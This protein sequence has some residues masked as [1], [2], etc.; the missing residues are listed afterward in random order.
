MDTNDKTT[1]AG[2]HSNKS[3]PPD[4]VPDEAPRP[5]RADRGSTSRK[6]RK[7][8]PSDAADAEATP[9][10]IGTP[11][12]PPTKDSKRPQKAPKT[13]D[14]QTPKGGSSN[15]NS[16]VNVK[17]LAE[18]MILY[19]LDHWRARAAVVYTTGQRDATSLWSPQWAGVVSQQK[20]CSLFDGFDRTWFIPFDVETPLPEDKKHI[21]DD[22]EQR[23]KEMKETFESK[24]E[25]IL[26][27]LQVILEQ[28]IET[29]C[30]NQWDQNWDKKNLPPMKW[31]DVRHKYGITEQVN[32]V[33]KGRLAD[34]RALLPGYY[35]I[36]VLDLAVD[37]KMLFQRVSMPPDITLQG[38][39]SRL[40]SWSVSKSEDDGKLL[41][42][43]RTKLERALVRGTTTAMQKAQNLLDQL[44][45]PT[46]KVDY[47]GSEM[48]TWVFKLNHNVNYYIRP[49]QGPA[50]IRRW[51]GLKEATF[52]EFV[53][54]VRAGKHPVV[55]RPWKVRLRRMWPD[56]DELDDGLPPDTAPGE[57]ELSLEQL[58]L[59]DELLAKHSD[60]ERQQGRRFIQALERV[61]KP[62][63]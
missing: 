37:G 13:G 39:L 18:E 53:Q 14:Q 47:E 19:R 35:T 30:Q 10:N 54:G 55:V 25:Y 27:R 4:E 16:S 15:N 62:L 22:L 50:D 46:F 26:P 59:V 9:T 29:K 3:R 34:G 32:L 56:I 1:N 6:V 52:D 51:K 5:T 21:A 49:A 36:I 58:E 38:F 41:D 43:V 12:P 11:N 28:E 48:D 20:G 44:N 7:T 2:S 63:E 57:P 45:K 42:L 24:R 60:E 33:A 17:K 40:E 8:R 23:G 61:R 31:S